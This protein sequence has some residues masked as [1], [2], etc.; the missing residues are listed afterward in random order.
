MWIALLQARVGHA[1]VLFVLAAL[2]RLMPISSDVIITLRV[3][4]YHTTGSPRRAAGVGDAHQP[5]VDADDVTV[6]IVRP[7]VPRVV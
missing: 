3:S 2:L 7:R 6:R 5:E 1:R 4:H